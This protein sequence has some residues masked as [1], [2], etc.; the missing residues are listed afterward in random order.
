MSNNDETKIVY[1]G[2]GDDIKPVL[3]ND[4]KIPYIFIY[5]DCQPFN[6]PDLI[7]FSIN[8]GHC[9][10]NKQWLNDT[11]TKFSSVDGCKMISH[12]TTINLLVFEYTNEN[13]IVNILKYYYASPFP[14]ILDIKNCHSVFNPSP[15]KR[16]SILTDIT[17]YDVL[18][19]AGYI[20][21][22][23]ILDYA[24]QECIDI[25]GS[26]HTVYELENYTEEEIKD[27]Q[28]YKD[29][30]IFYERI[31]QMI[32]SGCIRNW[33]YLKEF[34]NDALDDY[35]YICTITR[36]ATI[37]NIFKY[38]NNVLCIGTDLDI[39]PA[40]LLDYDEYIFI[41][42][43]P[44]SEELK[45]KFTDAGWDVESKN[46]DID[47][48]TFSNKNSIT[49]NKT[50]IIKLF[51]STSFPFSNDLSEDKKGIIISNITDFSG[52]LLNNDLNESILDYSNEF[53]IIL[54]NTDKIEFE[55]KFFNNLKDK[56]FSFAIKKI[57]CMNYEWQNNIGDYYFKDIITKNS[58]PGDF[59]EFSSDY[60]YEYEDMVKSLFKKYIDSLF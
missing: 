8:N 4:L 12:D 34:W 27:D 28:K 43:S 10:E 38:V 30:L 6:T 36:K 17:G 40:I 18:H 42:K 7:K 57:I 55:T 14:E 3:H 25:S 22:S 9:C 2:A 56:M 1:I 50:K 60:E 39:T 33:S 53:D 19:I 29:N 11:I 46:N 45:L 35:D 23:S 49:K 5:M 37:N 41:D 13:G 58:N 59:L 24:N 48:I 32:K 51:Y 16:E 15:K 47:C 26:N 44:Y 20:P 31:N 52:L 54:S 21:H